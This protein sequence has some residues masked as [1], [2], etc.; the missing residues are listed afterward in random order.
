MKNKDEI[1]L[2]SC[3]GGEMVFRSIDVALKRCRFCGESG[4]PG[5]NMYDIDGIRY[6]TKDM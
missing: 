6:F 2:W 1:Y 5:V 3:H 4:T